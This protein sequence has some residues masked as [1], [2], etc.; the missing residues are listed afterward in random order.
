MIAPEA[1]LPCSGGFYVFG[2]E[3]NNLK[4]RKVQY[5]AKISSK[6][7]VDKKSSL[8]KMKKCKIFAK[9]SCRNSADRE[10]RAGQRE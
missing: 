4:K 5:A 8:Q 10:K 1:G 9:I 2:K 3:N 6:N 7:G